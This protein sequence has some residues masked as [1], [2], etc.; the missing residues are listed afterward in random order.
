[1]A[2]TFYNSIDLNAVG[3]VDFNM[4]K[5]AI[6]KDKTLL[7]FFSLIINGMSDGFIQKNI[8]RGKE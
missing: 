6:L 2:E 3:R 5:K 7:E 1:M 4:F 8:E